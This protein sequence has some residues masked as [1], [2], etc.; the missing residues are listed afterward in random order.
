[1]ASRLEEVARIAAL[2]WST[3]GRQL[4]TWTEA[5]SGAPA[6]TAGRLI[7]RDGTTSAS[8]LDHCRRGRAEAGGEQV[9][10]ARESLLVCREDQMGC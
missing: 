7:S 6:R 1:M 8:D 4:I 9:L 2:L 5:A 3:H 10:L